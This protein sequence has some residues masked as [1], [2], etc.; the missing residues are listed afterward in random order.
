MYRDHRIAA[1]VPAY[2]EEDQIAGV[3]E[4]M[5]DFVDHILIVDD[6]SPD[7]TGEVARSVGDPRV[8]VI[9][10]EENQGVGGAI[11]TGHKRAL[12]L[13]A[14]IDVVMA[15][16][17]QMDP[18]YLPTLLDPIID[19]GYGFTKANRFSSM[20]SFQSM[21][22]V[23]VFGNIVLS[24]VTKLAS[25]YWHLFDPQNGYTATRTDVLRRMNLDRLAKRY[26]FENDFLVSL[27]IL[28]VRALDVDIPAKYG[29]EVSGISL[30]RVIP[31]ITWL[32]WRGFWRRMIVKHVVRSLSPI[33]VLFFSGLGLCLW[34]VAFGVWILTQARG[35]TSPT[36]GT[37]LLSV[38]PFLMG[39]QFLIFG[40]VLDI[41]ESPD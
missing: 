28:N 25:G 32:L 8:E 2:K 15:G 36:S 11:V 13:G 24:F 16:D 6:R 39:M 7:R 35:D 20:D 26:E 22:K 19:D 18:D 3:I 5:P 17:G 12:E 30:P 23:R 27:N 4:T 29:D 21:P 33:A 1:V 41:Q 10:H 31:A 40:M 34:G 37:V 9:C 38:A 14:D